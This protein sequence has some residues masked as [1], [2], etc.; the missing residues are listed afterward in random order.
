MQ[1]QMVVSGVTQRNVPLAPG[2]YRL[3]DLSMDETPLGQL[4]RV[5]TANGA[6]Y[7]VGKLTVARTAAPYPRRHWALEVPNP[8]GPDHPA[9]PVNL[10]NLSYVRYVEIL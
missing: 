9:G 7:Y 5:L 3:Q 1:R 6:D 10:L 4:A 2:V 8:G